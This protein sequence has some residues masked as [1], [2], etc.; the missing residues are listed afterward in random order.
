MDELKWLPVETIARGGNFSFQKF[1][2]YV[3]FEIIQN[4]IQVVLIQGKIAECMWVENGMQGGNIE[5]MAISEIYEV[6]ISVYF[7]SEMQ[8]T[9]SLAVIVDQVIVQ[10]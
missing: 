8:I 3:V 1:Q 9:Q 10:W 2:S 7:V 4:N 6:S 5:V